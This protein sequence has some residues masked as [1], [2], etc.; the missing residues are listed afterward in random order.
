MDFAAVHQAVSLVWMLAWIV[1]SM[2]GA[3]LW[4]LREPSR[5]IRMHLASLCLVSLVSMLGLV[6]GAIGVRL[7]PLHPTGLGWAI[8]SYISA[9]GLVVQTF[10]AR[11]LAGDERYGSYFAWMT[12]TLFFA[13]AAWMAGDAWFFAACW[14]GMDA[15]LIRLIAMQRR[16]RAAQAVARMTW[17]RLAPSMAGVLLLC[18]MAAWAGRSPSLD[19]GIRALAAHPH[20]SLVAGL[21]LGT[22]A[23]AQAGNWPFGR[24][25]LDSA[26][27][28]TPVSALMHA[29]LVNAGGL[30]LAKF[31]PVLAAAGPFPRALLLAFAWLSVVTGTGAI[32]VQAD[33]KRQLVASTMAQ[34]G[35]ML[36]ECAMGAYAVAIVHLVLHGIFK[37]S[38]F[39][40]SGY[41]V[42][43]PEDALVPPS[44]QPKRSLWPAV[45]GTL[46]LLA[47][48]APH[49]ADGM[50]LL[51]GLLL[52]AGCAIAVR[53]AADLQ[54][55]RWL[56]LAAVA[57]AAGA[58]EGVRAALVRAIASLGASN[59]HPDW[60]FAVLAAALVALQAFAFAWWRWRPDTN[61][62]M[63]A[64]AWLVHLSD[65]R[66]A[67]VEAQPTSL[68]QLVK[69]AILK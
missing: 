47:Y 29:G 36:M 21:L 46:F 10:S 12:W 61:G 50:R 45:A 35:L 64:Y 40:K 60:A 59:A 31:A 1:A 42:P 44:P 34:M 62:A 52:A 14:V 65:P 22:V 19:T 8:S 28:P 49:P 9:L 33:Y 30:L 39:L 55:G 51:S 15:G 13:S 41:A 27:T 17:A 67:S 69:E 6:T 2:T 68:K 48:V 53:L 16:S 3:L 26:V 37:A 63:L 4:P 18:G 66:P 32:L 57:A 25:L 24:W 38:L 54:A 56:G 20:A 58:A 43:A 11:H 5:R 7:G 23:L